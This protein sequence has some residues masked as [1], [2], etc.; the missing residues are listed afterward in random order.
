M[1]TIHAMSWSKYLDQYL[2]QGNTDQEEKWDLS[3]SLGDI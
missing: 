2:L 3:F 1:L